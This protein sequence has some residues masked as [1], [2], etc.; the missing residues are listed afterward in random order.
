MSAQL[1]I[2]SLGFLSLGV[3]LSAGVFG[4]LL[5]SLSLRCCTL[6][7][8]PDYLHFLE[9]M[10]C[11]YNMY[12]C[13]KQC[14]IMQKFKETANFTVL[15]IWTIIVISLSA[16]PSSNPQTLGGCTDYLHFLHFLEQ[17]VYFKNYLLIVIH[18]VILPISQKQPHTVI[19]M[20]GMIP[21]DR[22]MNNEHDPYS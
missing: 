10:M 12:I 15:S 4:Q 20:S 9:T 21:D 13:P 6:F 8:P 1:T 16:A 11:I 19:Y 3:F 18:Y 5:L 7:Q 2:L 17:N 14:E 22:T